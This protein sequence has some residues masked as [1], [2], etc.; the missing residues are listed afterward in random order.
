MS[1][2]KFFRR[3]APVLGVLLASAVLFILS[4]WPQLNEAFGG[5]Q[6]PSAASY[7]SRVDVVFTFAGI[8]LRATACLAYV[9][10]CAWI[11]SILLREV[12]P[13]LPGEKRKTL[14]KLAL[15]L[16]PAL[17]YGLVMRLLFVNEAFRPGFQIVS[18][19]FILLV[20]TCMGALVT[21]MAFRVLGIEAIRGSTLWT[22]LAPFQMMLLALFGSLFIRLEA[23]LCVVVAS[24]LMFVPTIAG[25]LLMGAFLKAN[26]RKLPVTVFVLLP[27]AMGPLEETWKAPAK[28]VV[29]TD[30]ID[31]QAPPEAVWREIA[32]V[33]AI[34]SDQV[35]FQ[36]IYFLDFPRPIAAVIDR[37]GVGARRLATFERGVSFFEVV[38]EWEPGKSLALSVDADPAFIPH[39]AFDE[40]IIVGGRFYDVLDGRYEIQTT[41]TGSR[42]VLSSTHRLSTPFNAYA[43]FWSTWVMN[44][45]Q[46]SILTVL[47]A[48]A[49]GRA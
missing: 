15:I 36:W 27:L 6:Q 31:I 43:G 26:Q 25:G 10:L 7:T 5:G 24:P 40:H 23:L 45:I 2:T 44:Q 42:L 17:F 18:L 47:K 39:T 29:I 49:E 33:P 37:E 8:A 41:A 11:F 16:I 4:Y 20:P 46:G 22:V 38:T 30:S 3:N 34:P 9:S 13:P 21:F 28:T 32:S 48:R 14:K 35:P 1:A 19:T 12:P